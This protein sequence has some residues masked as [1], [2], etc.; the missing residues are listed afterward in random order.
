MAGLYCDIS[1]CASGMELQI[2]GY[3]HKVHVL[4]ERLVATVMD[5]L[6]IETTT[7]IDDTTSSSSDE[8]LFARCQYKIE[9]A[10]NSFLVGQP[11]QHCIYGGDLVLENSRT[12]IQ[13]K[14]NTLRHLTVADV[15]TFGRGFL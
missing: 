14:L 9:Q 2:S 1:P 6:T 3:N 15:K 11:Y 4:A 12:T 5:L 8:E 13:D 10:L 7:T